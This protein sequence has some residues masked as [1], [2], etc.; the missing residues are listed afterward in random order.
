VAFLGN[1]FHSWCS[2]VRKLSGFALFA[3][4]ENY[5]VQT[6]KVSGAS[7]IQL[8]TISCALPSILNDE[9]NILVVYECRSS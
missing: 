5:T 6:G 2:A 8:G 7:E 3:C 4:Y 1:A 9:K